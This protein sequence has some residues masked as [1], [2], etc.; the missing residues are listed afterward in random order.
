MKTITEQE[1][2]ENT[3]LN[4]LVEPDSELKNII[5][6]YVGASSEE[7]MHNNEVTVQMIVDVFAKEFP[8][9]LMSVAEENW[10]RGYKQGINDVQIGMELSEKE[11]ISE[12][13]WVEEHQTH[14][15]GVGDV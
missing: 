11:N 4:E 10:I 6:E 13:Q 14:S 7:S 8:E 3:T 2:T 12:E 1:G 5:V 9:F 15:D